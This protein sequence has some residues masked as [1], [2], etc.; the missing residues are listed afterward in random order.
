MI[1]I[2]SFGPADFETIKTLVESIQEFERTYVPELKLG[3]EIGAAY[4]EKL[5]NTIANQQGVIFLAKTDTDTVGF[6]CAWIDEDDDLLLSEDARTHA[7]ISDIFV[8]EDWRRQGVAT[9]LLQAV[10]TEMRQR[11]CQRIR[12]CTKAANLSA[13]TCYKANG[14]SAYEIVLSKRLTG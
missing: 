10:E 5:V 9:L 14:Y 8:S 2:G 6:V 4:T 12:I 7:Y 3:V 13:L 11:G 1:S